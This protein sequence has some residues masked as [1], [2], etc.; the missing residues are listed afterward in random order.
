[1]SEQASPAGVW[2]LPRW[3]VLLAT[4][5]AVVLCTVTI[6]AVASSHTSTTALAW[7][8]GILAFLLGAAV[9]ALVTLLWLHIPLARA[10]EVCLRLESG[11]ISHTVPEVG[12][13]QLRTLARVL[14]AV[15]ADFQEVLLFFAHLLRSART[16]ATI[17]GDRVQS[18][19]CDNAIRSLVAAVRGDLQ[20]MQEIIEG[21]RYFR[22][23]L[24]DGTITDAG[25]STTGLRYT[26]RSSAPG[27]VAARSTGAT[28]KEE[29]SYHD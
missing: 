11:D 26:R 4:G 12:P 10:A 3:S 27:S 19:A 20:Q 6:A 2:R 13:V 21:F 16:S 22:V 25:V 24:E 18:D 23:R 28:G 9:S 17:L 8:I 29:E 14:N 5:I 7:M 1:M 15:L